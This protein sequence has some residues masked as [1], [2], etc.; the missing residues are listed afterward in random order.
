[1]ATR[2]NIVIKNGQD[3]L[4]FYR[5]WDGDPDGALPTLSKFMQWVAEGKI[6]DNVGQSA[7]W[8]ILIGNREQYNQGRRLR[9]RAPKQG[10]GL[11]VGS[12]HIYSPP[13][14]TPN[15]K[16]GADAWKVGS[17]QPTMEM[18]GDIAFLYILDLC[19]KTITV[20]SMPD[21]AFVKTVAFDAKKS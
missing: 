21:G 12:S 11:N 14:S 19:S 15:A 1:M 6:R 5:H 8:L 18:H 9:R 4:W 2:A 3:E 10:T 13:D 16:G 7:G 17:Y 20:K